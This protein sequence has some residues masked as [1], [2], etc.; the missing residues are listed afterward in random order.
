MMLFIQSNNRIIDVIE[1]KNVSYR[2]LP[3]GRAEYK[4]NGGWGSRILSV[5]RG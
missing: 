3:E 2:N 1:V 5:C 4:R